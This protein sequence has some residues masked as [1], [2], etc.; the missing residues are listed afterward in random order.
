[1]TVDAERIP[2]RKRE[3]YLQTPARSPFEFNLGEALRYWQLIPLF[4]RR[5]F[6]SEFSQTLLGPL[7]FVIHPV[8]QSIVFALLFGT[9]AKMSTDDATPFLFYNSA[10]VLWTYFAQSSTYV[11][12]VFLSNGGLFGKVQFP[13]VI[14]PISISFFRMVTLFANYAVFL[15]FLAF[16]YLRG[17]NV[18]PNL[19]VLATPLLFIHVA[20]LSFGVG[21]LV[22]AFTSRSRDMV[23]AF[24]YLLSLGMYATPIIYPLSA[25]PEKL[26]Y[27]FYL[28]PMA[29]PVELFRYAYLGSGSLDPTMYLFSVVE[30]MVIVLFGLMAFSYTEKTVVDTL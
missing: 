4:V 7:W 22:S 30:T 3:F 11:S 13:R 26:Y 12:Q 15:L 5:D 28:N 25:I 18:E 24:S 1:M 29:A 16:F 23:Q 2:S 19:W 14:V 17:A 27:L 9:L 20:L 6:V 21:T 8:M 10:L